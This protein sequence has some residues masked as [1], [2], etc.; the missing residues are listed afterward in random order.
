MPEPNDLGVDPS[1]GIDPSNILR[2]G[3]EGSIPI[4]AKYSG[5]RYE[6]SSYNFEADPRPASKLSKIWLLDAR[7]IPERL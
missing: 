3:I 1:M 2:F 5:G 6:L 4:H 7:V